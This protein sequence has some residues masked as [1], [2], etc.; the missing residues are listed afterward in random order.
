MH[1]LHPEN[2]VSVVIFKHT[3]AAIWWGGGLNFRLGLPLSPYIVSASSVGF[4]ETVRLRRH[5]WAFA[6][7]M[8]YAIGT[9]ISKASPYN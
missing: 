4:G 6:V 1:E 2:L 3:Y 7:R 5:V 9:K 8:S